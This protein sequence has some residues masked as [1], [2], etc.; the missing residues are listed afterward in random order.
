M[1]EPMPSVVRATGIG[2]NTI[3]E[4]SSS[5]LIHILFQTKCD[6]FYS[7][8]IGNKKERA[9]P[10]P[11]FHHLTLCERPVAL[12][13]VRSEMQCLER[14]DGGSA[15]N[16][17]KSLVLTRATDELKKVRIRPDGLLSLSSKWWETKS[18][19]IEVG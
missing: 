1:K 18:T 6:I 15:E 12:L 11:S 9:G 3:S 8:Y 5:L 13:R 14:E 4:A 19:S 7:A 16:L 2:G 10:Q 17:E